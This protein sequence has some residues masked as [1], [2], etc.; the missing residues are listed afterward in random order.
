MA[1]YNVHAGHC[2][3]GKGAYGAVG[4]LKE[5]VENRIVKDE[6]IRLLR[7][8]G[9]TVYDCTCEENTT[10]A[11]CLQKIVSKCN[12]HTVTLDVSVHLNSGRN[13]KKGD[14]K[15]G[16]VEVFCYDEKTK[17]FSERICTNISKTLGI[18]N[19]G[20]KYSKS[21]SVLANTKSPA[22]LVE[23]CFVD[24]RDDAD[25]WNAKQCARAIVEGILNK[26]ISSE[27][28]AEVTE[29]KPT[30]PEGEVMDKAGEFQ[31]KK[32]QTGEVS[33]QGHL[34]QSGWANW[35]CD[36]LMIGSV[37]Q[38]RRI[39]AIRIVPVMQMDVSV[40]IQSV[41]DKL[42]RNIKKET[43][44]GTTGEG[45][46]LEALKIESSDTIYLYRVHQK[47]L[48]W[49]SWCVNGQWAGKKGVSKQIEAIELKV[50]D[51]AY[52]GRIQE[53]GNT[54]WVADGM[55]AG[56]TG[57]QKSLE[58]I[59]IK[60]QHCGIVE[61]QAHIQGIGWKDYG[62]I[63]ENTIVGTEKGDLRLECL[64]LKGEFEWRAHIQGSGWTQWT[65]ADGIATL[66]TVGQSLRM[67]AVEMRKF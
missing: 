42:Y 39:E 59:R 18:T 19:R 26:K 21:F 7:R 8:E 20:T 14:G 9:H 34:R 40:H 35:Q 6:V 52:L 17:R 63:D 38:N 62:Q 22:I 33:Y 2:P 36:G 56:I 44:I 27:G 49:S 57:Q 43:V 47:D 37:G 4:I 23:C 15:T 66:G 29:K 30:N 51:L 13:D 50:A 60:S 54:A 67:E 5:S 1:V 32:D 12:Q 64:R 16:G 65:K 3:Q 53:S 61:A 24:D 11:G 55:T 46:A 45:R 41:G 28:T 31:S 25:K 58:A 10:Q 48:G